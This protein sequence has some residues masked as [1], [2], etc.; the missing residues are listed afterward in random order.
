MRSESVWVLYISGSELGLLAGTYGNRQRREDASAAFRL[1]NGRAS[2]RARDSLRGPNRVDGPSSNIEDA[3]ESEQHKHSL[4]EEDKQ[5]IDRTTTL[6]RFDSWDRELLVVEAQVV[7]VGVQ[8]V[9]VGWVVANSWWSG[10]CGYNFVE[11]FYAGV[12]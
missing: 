2:T 7:A 5:A 3:P 8:E 6:R 4:R 9:A 1:C 12:C 10:L 11:P